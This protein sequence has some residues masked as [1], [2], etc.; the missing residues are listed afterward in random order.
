[1]S[2]YTFDPVEVDPAGGRK[3][4]L[5]LFE[6]CANFWLPNEQFSVAEFVRPPTAT[7]FSYE[8]TSAGTSAA[9]APLWPRTIGVTVADGSVV[10]TCRAAGD[11]GVSVISGLSAVS[12]PIGLTI[13]GLSVNESTKILATYSGV[14]LGQ[15]YDAVYTFALNGVTRVARQAVLGRKL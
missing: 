5:D 7:G 12:D 4:V 8:C 15:D 10:W 9:R 3:V 6:Q 11:N 1:M 13:S 14:A 2:E